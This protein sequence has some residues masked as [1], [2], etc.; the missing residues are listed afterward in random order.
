MKRIIALIVSVLIIIGI[1]TVSVAQTPA[2]KAET[3]VKSNNTV[4]YPLK[5]KD[6]NGFEMTIP[7]EPQKI[8]SLT[9]ASDEILLSLV[10]KKRIIAISTTADDKGIS[11]VSDIAKSIPN[12]ITSKDIEKIIVFKPDLVFVANWADAKFVKQLRDTGIMVYAYAAP[13]SIEG[14]KKLVSEIAGLV[15]AKSNAINVNKSMDTTLE[16]VKAK[17]NTIKPQKKLTVL[18]CDS[19][20]CTYGTGTTFD[21]IAKAAG[22]INAATKAKISGI[23]QI[24]KEKVIEMNPDIIIL[25]GWSYQGFDAT[26]FAK[27]FKE[28][29]SLAGLKAIKNNRVYMV[30]DAHMT[31]I[32]QYITLA[33]GDVANLA[34]PD[35]FKKASV[36][37]V[38]VINAGKGGQ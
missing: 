23:V 36:K 28:D 34:Y 4:Q 8:A 32:S 6:A 5:V 1:F 10:D 35:L 31:S 18:Y 17:V 30:T 38:P 25:P 3:A 21:E 29:K 27:K 16:A 11:N 22:V 33:V 15:N 13:S 12:K 7:K 9:L 26:D 24:N 20:W 19:F 2:T 14:I 37:P